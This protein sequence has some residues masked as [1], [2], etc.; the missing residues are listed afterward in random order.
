MVE[1]ADVAPGKFHLT[2]NSKK[3]DLGDY[4]QIALI[5]DKRKMDLSFLKGY[6][7]QEPGTG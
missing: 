4:F 5:H 7:T 1:R 3:N 2:G 6:A